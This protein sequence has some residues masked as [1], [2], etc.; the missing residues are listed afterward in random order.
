MGTDMDIDTLFGALA[1]AAGFEVR[2][3]CVSDRE[4][5]F[6]DKGFADDYFIAPANIAVKVGDKWKF[7]NPANT[8]V[9]YGMLRWQE[10]GQEA[11]IT[12][13]NEPAWVKTPHSAPE[14]SLQKRVA[15]LR[16]NTDGTIEGDVTIEYTGH[17]AVDHKEYNDDD[18]TTEREETL[19]ES[20]KKRV[21]TAELSNV[22]IENVTDPIKPFIQSY[23]IRIPN[24][25]QRTGKRL[26]LQPA[27]F[28]YNKGPLFPNSNR[29]HLIYFHYPWSEEDRV[30]I[31]L[32]EGFELDNAEAPSRFGAH[33]LSQYDVKISLIKDP[34]QKPTLV[35]SRKFFF[36]GQGK[37]LFPTEAFKVLKQFFDELHKQDNHTISLKLMAQTTSSQN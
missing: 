24:Y 1:A 10:E 14:K 7:Y 18:T 15:K 13:A 11:L 33:D 12:D 26:L 8:Y 28:Q 30:E 9:P 21:S 17:F 37:I 25:A 4:D 35:Y 19:K 36:G 31:E 6:F 22:R 20:V 2:V 3:A 29:H 5:I 16:L 34:K 32:P 27:F 23:H